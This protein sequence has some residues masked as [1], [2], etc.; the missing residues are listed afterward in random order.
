[1]IGEQL[2]PFAAEPRKQGRVHLVHS[3]VTELEQALEIC[4]GEVASLLEHSPT[5]RSTTLIALSGLESYDALLQLLGHLD[6]LLEAANATGVIQAVGFHPEALF[7]GAPSTDPAN[8][9]ARAPLPVVHLL[10][11]DEVAQA[12]ASHPDPEGISTRNA[13]RLRTQQQSAHWPPF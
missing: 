11:E 12:I 3:P 2:C 8:Y 5:Q 1:M 4:A 6:A 10:R 9:A 13:E 7:E